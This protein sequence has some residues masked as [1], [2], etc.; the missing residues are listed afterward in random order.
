M[1]LNTNHQAWLVILIII[2]NVCA[3]KSTVATL[4]PNISNSTAPDREVVKIENAT[5]EYYFISTTKE[6]FEICELNTT[7][8]ATDFP[9]ATDSEILTSNFAEKPPIIKNYL[10]GQQFCTCDLQVGT[11]YSINST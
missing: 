7:C 4:K 2:D 8:N 9:N 3:E 6:P 10:M 5:M 11:L 1:E